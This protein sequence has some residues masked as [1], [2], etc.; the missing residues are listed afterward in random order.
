MLSD[1]QENASIQ[2]WGTSQGQERNKTIPAFLRSATTPHKETRLL[3]ESTDRK[4]PIHGTDQQMQS[5]LQVLSEMRHV[6]GSQDRRHGSE[7][8]QENGRSG[9]GPELGSSISGRIWRAPNVSTLPGINP[10][11]A[12]ED[13]HRRDIALNQRN[14]S[15]RES[16]A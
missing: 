7:S 9:S 13:A 2:R 14:S 15:I 12:A 4:A 10:I 16:R 6:E 5:R 8:V 3:A 1:E 11:P